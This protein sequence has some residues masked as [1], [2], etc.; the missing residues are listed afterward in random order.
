MQSVAL[1]HD[2]LA[3]PHGPG[4]LPLQISVAVESC[5]DRPFHTEASV[6]SI[7]MHS[8]RLAQVRLGRPPLGPGIV[9]QVVPFQRSA[10]VGPPPAMQN[11]PPEQATAY[12]SL[13]A[14]FFSVRQV[15]PFQVIASECWT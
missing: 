9:S 10:P 6:P 12:R 14:G 8:V 13:P 2:T 15:V 3:S 4:A 5:H 11:E 7:R 1:P